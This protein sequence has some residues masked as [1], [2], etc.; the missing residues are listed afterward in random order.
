MPI[1]AVNAAIKAQILAEALPYIQRFH[2]KTIVVKALNVGQRLGEDAGLVGGERIVG[3]V[4]N[5]PHTTEKTTE[6]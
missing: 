5:A 6:S 3:G 1:D 2:G 4:H